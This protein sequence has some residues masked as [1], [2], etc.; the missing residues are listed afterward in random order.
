ARL[1]RQVDP[2]YTILPC[3]DR[4]TC[5]DMPGGGR[6]KG[7]FYAAESRQLAQLANSG[8]N[9]GKCSLLG[10]RQGLGGCNPHTF[11]RLQPVMRGLLSC[12]RGRNKKVGVKTFWH[13]LGR[14]PVGEIAK[15]IG[16][17]PELFNTG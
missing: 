16:C 12:W 3:Q 15:V 8:K 7:L 14:N 5:N 4:H 17:Q 11:A 13:S 10:V 9:E 1:L 2:R 6:F